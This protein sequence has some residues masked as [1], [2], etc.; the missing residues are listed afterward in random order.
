M[1]TEAQREKLARRLMK[2]RSRDSGQADPR[3]VEALALPTLPERLEAAVA[4]LAP[5]RV[6]VPIFPHAVPA[7]LEAR[8]LADEP[9]LT[10]QD[11][12]GRRQ[13]MAVFSSVATLQASYPQA[14][15]GPMTTTKACLVALAGPA[16]LIV[17]STLAIPRPAVAALA[18]GDT[19]LPAWRDL[20][21][22]D[23]INDTLADLDVGVVSCEPAP[24]A[25][26]RLIVPLAAR[27]ERAR[28]VL[29]EVT[30]RLS[31]L[32]RLIVATDAIEIVPVAASES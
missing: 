8:D 24:H 14:R 4:A 1:V 3:L 25:R 26:D 23:L 15:P 6:I 10:C 22:L 5:S 20:E 16:R 27:G 17:D 2:P 12:D 29:T 9:D 31:K 21:L 11:L 28:A 13:A 19:W 7:S 32:S 18:Q 30:A